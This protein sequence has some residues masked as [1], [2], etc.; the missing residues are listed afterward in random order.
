[1]S[2]TGTCMHIRNMTR[3]DPRTR[4]ASY[5]WARNNIHHLKLKQNQPKTKLTSNNA[6][7]NAFA[8]K[9]S[10][11]LFSLPADK[12]EI[13]EILWFNHDI[14]IAHGC[15]EK[16]DCISIISCPKSAQPRCHSEEHESPGVSACTFERSEKGKVRALR[17]R[18]FNVSRMLHRC[19]RE[20]KNVPLLLR[21]CSIKKRIGPRN[22]HCMHANNSNILKMP[23][24]LRL[25]DQ[26]DVMQKFH[27]SL[28]RTRGTKGY[29]SELAKIQAGFLIT[30]WT[31]SRVVGVFAQLGRRVRV[32]RC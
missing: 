22:W 31:S 25:V 6:V 3:K 12:G 15:I 29:W 14:W 23:W 28:F 1:M 16:W 2:S 18:V 19:F 9:R 4:N 10:L 11:W 8:D 27:S 7:R 20:N 13:P 24:E 26:F 21:Y 5:A 30:T 32:E 17:V